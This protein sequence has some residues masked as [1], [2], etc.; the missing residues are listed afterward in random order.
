VVTQTLEC[1]GRIARGVE[2]TGDD[3]RSRPGRGDL[4]DVVE[5]ELAAVRRPQL[6]T[7]R[8]AIFS[9]YQFELRSR[10][11]PL[12]EGHDEQQTYKAPPQNGQRLTCLRFSF[13]R[14]SLV[15]VLWRWPSTSYYSR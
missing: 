9:V 15:A 7:Y 13:L 3:T 2:L 10:A 5:G 14:A 4:L 8:P 11:A 6:Q 1:F 12:T